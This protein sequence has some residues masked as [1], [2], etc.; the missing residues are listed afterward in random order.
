MAD[1]SALGWA[2]DQ[3]ACMELLRRTKVAAIPGGA[4]FEPGSGRDSK[5]LRF[6]YAKEL[7]VLEDACNRLRSLRD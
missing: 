1:F 7:D 2:D 5:L 6:C 4:F 3:Q